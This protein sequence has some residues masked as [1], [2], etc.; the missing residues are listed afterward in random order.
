MLKE[1]KDHPCHRECCH[2]GRHYRQHADAAVE[3]VTDGNRAYQPSTKV[4][5]KDAPGAY[6]DVPPPSPDALAARQYCWG[7]E[8]GHDLTAMM[9]QA[10][11]AMSS[12]NAFPLHC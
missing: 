5:A 8:S 4:S 2:N 9:A 12:I 6:G 11:W 3:N 1:G 10:S 7:G